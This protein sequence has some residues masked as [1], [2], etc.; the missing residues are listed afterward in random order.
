MDEFP[1]Q[2][3]RRQPAPPCGVLDHAFDRR[4]KD[5]GTDIGRFGAFI[6]PERCDDGLV[7]AQ[8]FPFECTLDRSRSVVARRRLRASMADG[9][10]ATS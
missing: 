3:R 10:P 6:V 4:G 7:A 2:L 9:A 8:V 1:S 5:F